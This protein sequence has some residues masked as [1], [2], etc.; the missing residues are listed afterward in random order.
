MDVA[1]W[2]G[3]QP[4]FLLIDADEQICGPCLDAEGV[5]VEAPEDDELR[6]VE[7]LGCLPSRGCVATSAGPSATA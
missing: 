1:F 4:K 5:F 7:I 3:V 6:T 2:G